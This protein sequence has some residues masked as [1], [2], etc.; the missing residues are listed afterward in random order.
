[1]KTSSGSLPSSGKEKAWWSYNHQ[2]DP[3]AREATV[4][5]NKIKGPGGRTLWEVA[6]VSP[7]ETPLDRRP[8]RFLR[9]VCFYSLPPSLVGSPLARSTLVGVE[10]CWPTRSEVPLSVPSLS[11]WN[12]LVSAVPVFI[13]P[14]TTQT[15]AGHPSGRDFSQQSFR[16]GF[17]EPR[18]PTTESGF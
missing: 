11:P 15:V 6:C 13:S 10:R 8:L 16:L 7:S 3:G 1:M 9:G 12:L 2:G 14:E 4:A 18:V 17:Q 5:N